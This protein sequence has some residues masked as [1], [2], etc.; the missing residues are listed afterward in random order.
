MIFFIITILITMYAQFKVQNN[1][2]KYSQ[3]RNYNNMTGF[4]AARNILDRNGLRDVRIERV[5]GSL[6]DHYSPRE[7]ILRLSET[8]HDVPSISAVAVAAHE[9]G[10]AIQHQEG[11]GPLKFRSFM[12]P[13]ANFGSRFSYI[14][15]LGGL[16]LRA[17]NLFDIGIFLFSL[18]VIFYLIT[19]P[20]EFN[21]SKRALEQLSSNGFIVQNEYEPAKDVLQA[22]GLTY[23]ASALSAV[24]Y[25][26][27]LLALRRRD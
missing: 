27:R 20:V 10:H 23:L 5:K 12:V 19:L 4:E 25:L 8:V 11:Y 18:A 14:L 3:V 16:M 15:I 17:A 6:S 22:A 9:V 26:L 1:F 24:F 7:R 13:L 2:N 21:A